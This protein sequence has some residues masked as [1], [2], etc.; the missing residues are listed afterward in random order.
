MKKPFRDFLTTVCRA[1]LWL[2]ILNNSL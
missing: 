1:M 2:L